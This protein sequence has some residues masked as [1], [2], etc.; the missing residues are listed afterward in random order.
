MRYM[1]LRKSNSISCGSAGITIIRRRRTSVVV[2]RLLPLEMPRSSSFPIV[3]IL[4]RFLQGF[5]IWNISL[6]SSSFQN[7]SHASSTHSFSA[8]MREYFILTPITVST[9]DQQL[10]KS[11]SPVPFL[12]LFFR[13]LGANLHVHPHNSVCVKL[14]TGKG[15]PSKGSGTPKLELGRLLQLIGVIFAFP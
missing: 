2:G 15:L 11:R 8:V 4:R 14:A 10:W 13:W 5:C 9:Y 3:S 7:I 6:G 1:C 12:P